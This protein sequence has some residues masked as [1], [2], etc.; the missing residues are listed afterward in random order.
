[1][2]CMGVRQEVRIAQAELTQLQAF[3]LRLLLKMM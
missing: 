3:R 2:P 1:M